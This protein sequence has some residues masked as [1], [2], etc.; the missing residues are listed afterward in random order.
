M[1]GLGVSVEL[2]FEHRAGFGDEVVSL[3]PGW[4]IYLAEDS[5]NTSRSLPPKVLEVEYAREDGHR[6]EV[7]GWPL[8]L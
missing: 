5:E 3:V 6:R 1:N 4:L 2:G 8:T 7:T